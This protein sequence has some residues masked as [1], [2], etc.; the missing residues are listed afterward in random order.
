M[1]I[2]FF[3]KPKS[4]VAF[5]YDDETLR[6]VLEKMEF[7]RYSSIPVISRKSG[8]YVGSITEGDL[9]W[10][11]KN[12]FE[13]SVH[14]AEAISIQSVTR[15]RD[16]LPVSVNSNMEDLI[17]KV[18]NQNFVPVIDDNKCFIG[19]IT[20]KDVIQYLCKQANEE[21]REIM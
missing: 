2:L 19:I 5:I 12:K 9:L 14:D 10:Y 18:T 16:N 20:R 15:K 1:N 17:E 8:K 7:H 21:K 11:I 13:L 6:Q 3:L 4:D